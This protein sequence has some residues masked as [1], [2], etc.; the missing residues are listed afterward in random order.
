M[1]L[2]SRPGLTQGV[3]TDRDHPSTRNGI[4]AMAGSL[5]KVTLI[6][7]LGKD[8]ETRYTGSAD[9]VCTLALA[10]S[11][12]WTPAGGGERQE[13]T[14]WHTVV[15]WR[16]LA[17]QCAEYLTKGTLVLI[18]GRIETRNW[19]DKDTGKKV[20]RTEII[21]DNMVMLDAKP[22]SAEDGN[23]DDAGAS[24]DRPVNIRDRREQRSGLP[25]SRPAYRG[26]PN[27][28]PP[29]GEPVFAGGRPNHDNV[30]E[31]DD[32]PF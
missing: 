5:N 6:G 26:T 9:Q 4:T 32:T 29:R 8:H 3:V 12:T 17:E 7:R 10:T 31:L 2:G 15:A 16:K 13:A 23:R 20:Y 1:G 25:E 27:R 14:E 11:R 19:E 28:L 24:R 22:A 21:A 30:M 18:E